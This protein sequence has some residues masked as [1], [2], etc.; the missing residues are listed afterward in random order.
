[1]RGKYGDR[2]TFGS[3]ALTDGGPAMPGPELRRVDR[4]DGLGDM[5]ETRLDVPLDAL[6]IVHAR[7]GLGWRGQGWWRGRG[8]WRPDRGRGSDGGG[9]AAQRQQ[10]GE[11]EAESPCHALSS[12]G[13]RT[14][15]VVP[16][17]TVDR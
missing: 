9:G 12:R 2:R 3:R 14:M 5:G 11:G 1:M 10:G 13:S 17:P 4:V 16:R 8:G 7:R 15:T 6:R